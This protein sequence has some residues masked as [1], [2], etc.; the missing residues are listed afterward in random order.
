MQEVLDLCN[1]GVSEKTPQVFSPLLPAEYM[2]AF[3]GRTDTPEVRC[4]LTDRQTHT[5][6]HIYTNPTTVI[7]AAHAC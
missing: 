4:G 6:T 7:L 3:S 2:T 5:H 1:G